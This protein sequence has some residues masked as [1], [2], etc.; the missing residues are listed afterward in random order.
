MSALKLDDR[1]EALLATVL[2]PLDE[3][4]RAM[5]GGVLQVSVGPTKDFGGWDGDVWVLDERLEGPAM[6]H[7]SEP[8]AHPLDRWRRAMGCVL[9]GVAWSQLAAQ[10][11]PRTP[12]WWQG[13]A[14]AMADEAA[15]YLGLLQSA[16]V[17]AVERGSVAGR[18][19]A[20]LFGRNADQQALAWSRELRQAEVL[21][22]LEAGL[23]A[24]GLAID[25]DPRPLPC[26]AAAFELCRIVATRQGVLAEVDWP[27]G[28][29][30]VAWVS[31]TPAELSLRAAAVEGRWDLAS[32]EVGGQILGARGVTLRF[33][34]NGRADLLF[35]DAFVGPLEALELARQM[36][37][38]GMSSGTWQA[39]G[40]GRIRFGAFSASPISMHQRDGSGVMP[41][42]GFGVTEWVAAIARTE[43]AI[44]KRGSGLLL[45]GE[46][47]GM[48]VQ[49]R[50][51]PE[52]D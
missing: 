14:V 2:Q 27:V 24:S 44:N 5:P 31:L 48:R 19:A 10:G 16:R 9:E 23:S 37:H 43:W 4:L 52:R 32:T 46:L 25:G 38:S 3:A 47:M 41:Q 34:R 20:L 18:G 50:L 40:P 49:M 22:R 29:E 17:G 8:D 26:H 6:H 42:V 11:L 39:L 13:A 51:V 15:P 33:Y 28:K 36:G 21:S 12:G 1:A 7:P 45:E 30:P 35:A